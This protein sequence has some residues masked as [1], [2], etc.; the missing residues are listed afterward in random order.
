MSTL[1]LF[2]RANFLHTKSNWVV[3]IN[4][5]IF[6]NARFR[7]LALYTTD[8][9]VREPSV[10]EIKLYLWDFRHESS[11]AATAV[12]SASSLNLYIS[13]GTKRSFYIAIQFN[14]RHGMCPIN[15]GTPQKN[16]FSHVYRSPIIDEDSEVNIRMLN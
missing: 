9:I 11:L 2:Y 16:T 6:P 1:E 12:V 10:N 14:Y 5:L 8:E 13:Y 7:S 4:A 3:K 15:K